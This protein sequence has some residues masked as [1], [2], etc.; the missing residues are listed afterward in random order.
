MVFGGDYIFSWAN[1]IGLNIRYDVSFY[2]KETRIILMQYK[3]NDPNVSACF[4]SI[5]GSLVYSY[6]TFTE[7]QTTK[8][9]ENANKLEVKGKVAV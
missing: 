5:A 1:F 3:A 7:E 4:L 6:I 8:Q 2:Q 9:S